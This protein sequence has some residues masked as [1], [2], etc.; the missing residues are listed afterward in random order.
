MEFGDALRHRRMVRRFT[1]EP[2]TPDQAERIASAATRAP[3]AGNSQGITVVSITDPNRIQRVAMACGEQEYVDRGFK[4]WLSTAGQHLAL[5]AE[6]Q[7]Y[8]DRYAEADKDDKA[9]DPIPWWW[10]DAGAALMAM[11]LA[12]VD[13][14]LA[15]GFHG[16][17]KADGARPVFGLP[18]DVVMVGIVAVGHPAP[19]RGSTSRQRPKRL[20]SV[21]HETW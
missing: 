2:I 5:C 9:L 12:A 1:G 15:A 3:T 21:R 11:L 8:R 16:G 7:R 20:D 10:V 19:D 14:G 13:E 4:P 6:P 17:H 18:E